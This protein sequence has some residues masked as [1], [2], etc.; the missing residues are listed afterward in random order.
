MSPRDDGM[1]RDRDGSLVYAPDDFWRR[2]EAPS[3]A[4]A[5]LEDEPTTHECDNGWLGEAA[6][7][8]PCPTCKPH[9]LELQKARRARC[10]VC[11]L[12]MDPVLVEQGA[13][14]HPACDPDAQ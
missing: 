6:N 3:L 11:R 12:R 9:V 4:L 5:R 8:E 2:P 1:I 7:P 13:T 14:T 10:Q